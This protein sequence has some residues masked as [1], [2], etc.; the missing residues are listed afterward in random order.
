MRPRAADSTSLAR[1][2]GPVQVGSGHGLA[3]AG[4]V[5]AGL[6]G[7]AAAGAFW[8]TERKRTRAGSRIAPMLA[9]DVFASR[10][11]RWINVIT[12][13]V[14]AA[15]SGLMFLLVLQLQVV[16]GFSPLKAGSALLPVML[17]ML[18][19]SPHAGA[20]AQRIG[21]RLPM[22]VGLAGCAIGM[23]LMARIGPHARYATD[24]LPGVVTYGLGV[25]FTVAPLTATVLA[26]ANVRHAGLASGVNNAVAR[27]AGLLAVAAL[28]AAVGLGAASYHQPAL[29]DHGFRIA[30]VACAVMLAVAAALSAMLIDSDV[31]LPTSVTARRINAPALEP[32]R[33]AS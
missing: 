1:I 6:L 17:I 25:S 11:F 33:R 20:L 27:A 3:G 29:F 5:L 8:Q 28:P 12:F 4:P 30:A 7:V 13:L 21:P 16:A 22:T 24:V 32:V 9:L 18:V 2:E 15:F 23:L 31:L 26:S 14:Y 19:L 10:Q